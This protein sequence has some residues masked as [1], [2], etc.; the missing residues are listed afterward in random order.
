MEEHIQFYNHKISDI[1]KNIDITTLNNYQLYKI[2]EYYSCIVL[3]KRD[4]KLYFVYSDVSPSF[5][6]HNNL[7]S[8][9][10]GIDFSD[11]IDTIGQCKYYGN[12]STITY[13]SLST[14]GCWKT[15]GD[16]IKWKNLILVRTKDSR[17]H[18]IITKHFR[19]LF[20]DYPLDREDFL[21][22]LR[23]L[24]K[25]PVVIPNSREI[26]TIRPYQQQVL[27]ILHSSD[28]NVTI[29]LP[30]GT[31][32]SFIIVKY[33]IDCSNKKFLILVPKIVLMYQWFEE[34]QKHT[35]YTQKDIYLLCNEQKKKYD[36]QRIVICVYDSIDKIDISIFY[37][38][39]IDEAHHIRTPEMY[40]Q[41]D[42]EDDQPFENTQE[43][44]NLLTVNTL[45][46]LCKERTIKNYSNATH[47]QLVK[48]LTNTEPQTFLQKIR[49]MYSGKNIIEI[50]ATIDSILS[51]RYYEFT[52]RDAIDQHYL[53]DYTITVPVFSTDIDYSK[54]SKY[55][56]DNLLYNTIVL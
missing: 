43:D 35:N 8:A 55:L 36:K 52:I 20:A 53:C 7:P 18:S 28:T 41:Q 9:D 32:K 11:M 23:T 13:R 33:T 49:N 38:I 29:R 44:Y 37:K 40:K 30:T 16:T 5:K 45:R 26:Y 51:H 2:F 47:S 19:D 1:V 22:Y 56:I 31:G 50:S 12:N 46:K 42:E 10:N 3:S 15:A 14:F 27:D 34:Y 21:D 24:Q 39:V 25:Y 6:E 4:N 48:L 17:L 54:I